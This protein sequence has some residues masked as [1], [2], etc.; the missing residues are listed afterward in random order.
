MMTTSRTYLQKPRISGV[1][2]HRA[3]CG[4]IL[5]EIPSMHTN[6]RLLLLFLAFSLAVLSLPVF[7]Q[8]VIATLPVGSDPQSSAVN[9]TTN[10]IYV[11]NDC[12]NDP[13][14]ADRKSTRLNSSHL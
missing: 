13:N 7:A 1:R 8:Q 12:G 10:K 4:K 6:R 5:S 9:S 3:A 14:C 11:A 2:G